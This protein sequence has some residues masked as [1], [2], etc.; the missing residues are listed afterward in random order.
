MAQVVS[1]VGSLPLEQIVRLRQL[2]RGSIGR[3]F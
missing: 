3:L 2:F 1:V